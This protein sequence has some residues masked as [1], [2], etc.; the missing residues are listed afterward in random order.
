MK[1]AYCIAIAM[2]SCYIVLFGT[3]RLTSYKANSQLS[4][5]LATVLRISVTADSRL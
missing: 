1:T 3:I 5:M 4:R 2:F